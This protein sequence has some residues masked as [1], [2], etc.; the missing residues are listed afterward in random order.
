[1][2]VLLHFSLLFSGVISLEGH[3]IDGFIKGMSTIVA[4]QGLVPPNQICPPEPLA[5]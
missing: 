3:I 2:V 4:G 1:M 5:A